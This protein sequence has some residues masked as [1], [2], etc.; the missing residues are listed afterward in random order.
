MSSQLCLFSCLLA[1]Y[2]KTT[3]PIFTKFDRKVARGPRK[4]R[5]DF[6]DGPNPAILRKFLYES[7]LHARLPGTWPTSSE[8]DNSRHSCV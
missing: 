8:A 4:K 3:R 6:D 1:R 2:A 5:L 7:N